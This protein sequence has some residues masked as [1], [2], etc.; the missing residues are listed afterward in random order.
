[1]LMGPLIAL[2]TT[3]DHE[4]KSDGCKNRITLLSITTK[5]DQN[6]IIFLLLASV[7]RSSHAVFGLPCQKQII[8]DCL[9]YEISCTEMK[10]ESKHLPL[11]KYT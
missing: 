5:Y 2:L 8:W 11:P 9:N 4:R 3:H 1:M 10:L 7:V 6:K